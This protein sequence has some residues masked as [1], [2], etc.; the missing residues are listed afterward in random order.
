M[1]RAAWV[2]CWTEGVARAEGLCGCTLCGCPRAGRVRAEV[3]GVCVC[4][5]GRAAL[6]G[7]GEGEGDGEVPAVRSTSRFCLL[8]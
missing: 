1:E 6:V 2:P 7:W 5:L 3:F 8:C 4:C